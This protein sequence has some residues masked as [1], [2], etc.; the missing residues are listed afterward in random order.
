[1][2]EL[3]AALATKHNGMKNFNHK[4]YGSGTDLYIFVNSE[5]VAVDESFE[6]LFE[7]AYEASMTD[8]GFDAQFEGDQEYYNYVLSQL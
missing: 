4:V 6:A 3:A 8:E 5:K 7:K 2:N 1:M